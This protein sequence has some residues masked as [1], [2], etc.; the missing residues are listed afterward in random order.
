MNQTRVSKEQFLNSLSVRYMIRRD[1]PEVLEIEWASFAY[2]LTEEDFLHNLRQ[3]NCIGTVAEHGEKVVGFMIY[4]SHKYKFHILNFAV[5]SLYRRGG[6]GSYMVMR[7]IGMLPHPLCTRR[8]TLEVRETNL[9]A[10]LFFRSRGFKAVKVLPRFYED[11]GEDAYLMQYQLG[12]EVINA[13]KESF[14]DYF[15]E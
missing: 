5:H 4:E 11:S 9:L 10:Q 15:D 3:G 2:P 8:I 1:I 7:L 12:P 13:E 6:V 14:R